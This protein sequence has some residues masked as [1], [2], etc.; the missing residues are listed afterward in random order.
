MSSL[1]QRSISSGPLEAKILL[2]GEAPGEQEVVHGVPFVGGSGRELDAMLRECGL[3]REAIRVTNVCN[4]RPPD[5]WI[6]GK[7]R[8]NDIAA[9][10]PKSAKEA[11]ARGA[12]LLQNKWVTQE[13]I[14]GMTLLRSEMQRMPNLELVLGA[15]NTPLW[16]LNSKDGI[17][18]WR[19]S[20]LH[21]AFSGR[22][23]PFVPILHP[24]SILRQ[25]SQRWYTL[26]D[27]KRALRWQREHYRIPTYDFLIRPSFGLSAEYLHSLLHRLESG[28]TI[29]ASVDVETRAGHIACVGFALSDRAAICIPFLEG[30]GSYWPIDEEIFLVDL[31]RR[32]LTH[33]NIRVIGQNYLYDRQYFA[34]WWGIRARLDHD[35]MVKQHVCFPGVPKGLD[36]LS[37]QYNN[38]H[39]YWKGE[40]K[41]WDPAIGEEQ[42]WTYNCKDAVVTYEANGHLDDVVKH[43]K[44]EGRLADQMAT[45]EIAF[46]AMLR[47]IPVDFSYRKSLADSHALEHDK[48]SL[49]TKMR[50]LHQFVEFCIGYPILL[51]SAQQVMK[52]CYEVFR[53]PHYHS[54]TSGSL[55][56]SKD[57]IKEW[58]VTCEPIFRPILQA[59]EDYRSLA[60]FRNT[61]ALAPID[62]DGRFRCSINVTG[63][64]TFRWSTSED[65]FGYGTNMQNLPKG[66]ED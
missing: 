45:G 61:F 32:I 49:A 54:S 59:I 51:S 27:I 4:V 28:E 41:D 57:A 47:G 40:S 5:I 58:L 3:A 38:Y 33:R 65:A 9:F 62:P 24:A 42:L 48:G 17:T 29:Q 7:Q 15:G 8:R 11:K 26:L 63:A 55:S 12:K 6:G 34:K 53:L 23:I 46:N 20:Q 35:T 39:V 18:S 2:V 13:I 30:G 22:P 56:A 36:F 43:F 19:G 64:A 21:T 50:E 52:L 60:T 44:S 1:S 31:I 16:A 37:A 14:D 66:D 25:W 10:M